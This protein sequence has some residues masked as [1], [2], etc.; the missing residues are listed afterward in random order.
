MFK[1]KPKMLQEVSPSLLSP[2]FERG[3]LELTL[4]AFRRLRCVVLILGIIS[5]LWYVLLM[6]ALWK[7]AAKSTT[8]I[9]LTS[10]GFCDIYA[11]SQVVWFGVLSVAG[12]KEETYLPD[13]WL[14]LIHSS[15]ELICLPHYLTI[16]FNRITV[17]ICLFMW[18]IP[19]GLNVF[20]HL[21][22]EDDDEGFFLF[23]SE[24]FT[25]SSDLDKMLATT[26]QMVFDLSYYV[27]VGILCAMY[28]IAILIYT[29]RVQKLFMA[30]G[31]TGP[32]A[33]STSGRTSTSIPLELRL[34]IVCLCNLL[35]SIINSIYDFVRPKRTQ[36]EMLIYAIL[37][38]L[39]NNINSILLPLFSQLLRETLK[40]M[41][42]KALFGRNAVSTGLVITPTPVSTARSRS[43]RREQNA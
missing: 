7:C 17:I 12:V 1:P 29:C 33:G 22:A 24:T 42:A 20:L 23:D 5:I 38:L 16:A 37:N 40:K 28:G 30:T 39:D 41:L 18:L 26:L 25:V 43:T 21:Q 11:L 14:S 35:P 13:R 27:V 31:L 6:V 9:L 8:F 3:R 15:F 32:A 19:I 4:P 36:P 10:Q 2:L 34:T